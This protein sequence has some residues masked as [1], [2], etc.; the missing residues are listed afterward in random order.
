[1]KTVEI[2]ESPIKERN[3]DKFG[4]REDMCECCGKTIKGK[5]F[6]F[7][8]DE[9]WEAVPIDATIEEIEN[10]PHELQG[11][12]FIGSECAKKFPKGYVEKE[13]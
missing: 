2:Y 12:F 8:A 10:H 11:T 1:M 13:K 7:T 3:I 9:N 5:K 4:Y 6:S